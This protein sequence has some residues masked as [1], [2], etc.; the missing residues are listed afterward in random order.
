MLKIIKDSDSE[1]KYLVTNNENSLMLW[2]HSHLVEL[3]VTH[4]LVELGDKVTDS[5]QRLQMRNIETKGDTFGQAGFVTV[6]KK[7][8]KLLLAR[9]A[10]GKYLIGSMPTLDP[11][12]GQYVLAVTQEELNDLLESIKTQGESH[13]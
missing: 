12:S 11:D 3:L 5:I 6:P 9:D 13:E 7:P 2:L 4:T 1:P 8:Y 10:A